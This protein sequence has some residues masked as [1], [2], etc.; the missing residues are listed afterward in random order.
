M[1]K[2]LFLVIA[3]V[4][5]S[6]AFAAPGVYDDPSTWKVKIQLVD[7]R[8]E[9]PDIFSPEAYMNREACTGREADLGL[10]FNSL[11]TIGEKIWQIVKAGEPVLNFAA[12]SVSAIPNG[13]VCPFNMEGWS[14]PQSRTYRMTY[15]NLMG[16]NMIDFTYKVIFSY[17]GSYG[18]R[19][20]Y[21]TNVSIHP[22]NVAVMWGQSFNANVNIANTLNIGTA[23]NPVAGMQV[24][25]EW[26]VGNVVNKFKSQ[27][28]YFVEGRGSVQEL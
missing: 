12:N 5:S 20:A 17:G 1:S 15:T 18:G 22:A 24:I 2:F 25:L 28:I 10:D 11:I 21:L 14:L 26:D 9:M 3:S 27:R 4:F 23:D 13:A 6:A 8:I 16:M 19:G 7:E